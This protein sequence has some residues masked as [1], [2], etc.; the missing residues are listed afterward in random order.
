MANRIYG[1][2]DL[3]GVGNGETGDHYPVEAIAGV[4]ITY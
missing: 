3:I 1:F 4:I 2:I